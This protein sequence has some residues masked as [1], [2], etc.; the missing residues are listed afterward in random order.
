MIR[1]T[2]I[3]IYCSSNQNLY[4]VGVYV[5]TYVAVCV[6]KTEGVCWAAISMRS[7]REFGGECARIDAR[8]LAVQVF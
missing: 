1:T 7:T 4:Q 3:N 2:T 6:H 5:N 8:K